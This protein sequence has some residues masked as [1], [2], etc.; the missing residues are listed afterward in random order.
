MIPE[1]GNTKIK[2]T[3]RL[4]GLIG[5]EPKDE[6]ATHEEV[7]EVKERNK[8]TGKME[9]VKKTVFINKDG[10]IIK[11]MT[12]TNQQMGIIS[13]LITD[14]TIIGASEEELTRAVKHSMVVIDAEKHHLDYK[15]SERDNDIAALQRKFQKH[16]V[17]DKDGNV[18]EKYGGAST[19]LSLKGH[20]IRVPE[21]HASQKVGENGEKLYNYTNR[22][23]EETK[24]IVSEDGKKATYVK[25]GKIK[26]AQSEVP[27][28]SEYDDVSIFSTGSKVEQAY[29][30]YANH[31]KAQANKARK[32]AYE[33]KSS[34]YSRTNRNAFAEEVASINTKLKTNASNKPRE[35]AAM[36]YTNGVMKA[37]RQDNPSMSSKEAKKIATNVLRNARIIKGADGKGTK[38]Q[39]SQKEWDAI[40]AG[41]VSFQAA[42]KVMQGMRTEDLQD[43]AMPKNQKVITNS[44]RGKMKSMYNSGNYTI[45]EIAEALGVSTS[46]VRRTINPLPEE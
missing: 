37:I 23:Y 41:A 15:A 22:Y 9:T 33:I 26:Q 43:L 28:F 45:A 4:A 14:M 40:M 2:S 35:Q 25:T 36:V 34:S 3:K 10:N 1:T 16:E 42:Y 11:P 38:I 27:L 12:Q 29:A 44:E 32:E 24:K 21:R 6:Y 8:T 5:F 20:N 7:R 13:N 18:V 19:L 46:T 39:L 30:S 17:V 31:M